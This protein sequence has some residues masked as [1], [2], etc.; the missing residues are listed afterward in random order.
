MLKDNIPPFAAEIDGMAELFRAEQ[1]E[2]DALDRAVTKLLPEFRVRTISGTMEM[3]EDLLGFDH[4]SGWEATRR[5]ERIRARLMAGAP[6]TPALLR[7]VIE[8]VGGVAV[9]LEEDADIPKVWV[10]FVGEYG[11]PAYMADIAR[12]VE[13]LRPYHVPVEYIYRMAYLA[14]YEG[15]TVEGLGGYQLEQ[16]ARGEPLRKGDN[17]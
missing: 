7:E 3:W 5:R 13:R 8:R 4:P 16:L 11:V 10:T 6:M 1:P 15:F 9:E 14:L 2:V 17:A 12:E